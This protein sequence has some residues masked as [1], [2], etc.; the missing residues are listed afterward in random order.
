MRPTAEAGK[1][2]GKTVT[3]VRVQGGEIITLQEASVLVG[4]DYKSTVNNRRYRGATMAEALGLREDELEIL[5]EI[6][7][8]R[9]KK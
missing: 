6:R 4:L 5:Q 1:D 7:R 2:A 8:P 3:L 9:L